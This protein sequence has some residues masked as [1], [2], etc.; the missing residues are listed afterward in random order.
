MVLFVKCLKVGCGVFAQSGA[1]KK[2]EKAVWGLCVCV[3][4][5]LPVLLTCVCL[6]TVYICLCGKRGIR[7]AMSG[8][9][10][11]HYHRHTFNHITHDHM[12]Q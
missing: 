1:Q 3:C 9:I 11:S 4:V 5:I 10:S 6:C 7:G 12:L 8:E 2:R